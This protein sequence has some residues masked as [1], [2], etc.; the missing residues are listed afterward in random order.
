MEPIQVFY[1]EKKERSFQMK[2]V[3]KNGSKCTH[4]KL[5]CHE[6]LDHWGKREHHKFPEAEKKYFIRKIKK[7]DLLIGTLEARKNGGSAYGM[8]ENIY[9]SYI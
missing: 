5:Y 9:K 7:A 1:P 6:I 4:A 3:H 8:E 2:R